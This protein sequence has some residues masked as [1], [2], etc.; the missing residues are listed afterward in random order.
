M[1][2]GVHKILFTLGLFATCTVV[3][4]TDEVLASGSKALEPTPLFDSKKTLVFET[5]S[6]DRIAE[7]TNEW[8]QRIDQACWNRNMVLGLL[9]TGLLSVAWI[10][11][12]LERQEHNNNSG[13]PMSDEEFDRLYNQY[14]YEKVKHKRERA[15]FRGIVK[16]S[17][18]RAVGAA[19]FL[20]ISHELLQKF[21]GLF[22]KLQEGAAGISW[23]FEKEQARMLLAEFEQELGTFGD[24]VYDF[25]QSCQHFQ[26]RLSQDDTSKLYDFYAVSIVTHHAAMVYTTEKLLAFICAVF[27]CRVNQGHSDQGMSAH[28]HNIVEGVNHISSEFEHIL[29]SREHGQEA[30][31]FF[32]SLQIFFKKMKRTVCN[33]AKDICEGKVA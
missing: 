25:L 10:W 9:A 17:A 8:E 15:T 30:D 14:L 1:K 31:S 33:M 11:W 7:F 18:L 2:V 20:F 28:I 3:G 23:N 4:R 12:K 21:S 13:Q 16:D 19:I 27:G 22:D 29:S 6:L 5:M 24:S 32:L 26:H